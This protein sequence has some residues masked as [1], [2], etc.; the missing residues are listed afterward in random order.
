MPSASYLPPTTATAPR[1]GHIDDI[2]GDDPL[3]LAT[4]RSLMGHA[5]PGFGPAAFGFGVIWGV[6]VWLVLSVEAMEFGCLLLAQCIE[7]VFACLC[8]C[9]CLCCEGL[10]YFFSVLG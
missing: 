3:S 1:D 2:A 8:V 9:C 4:K 6:W 5:G 7:P 10:V